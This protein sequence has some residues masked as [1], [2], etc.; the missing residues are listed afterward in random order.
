M[1]LFHLHIH[2]ELP[3]TFTNTRLIEVGGEH[4]LIHY[5][6]PVLRARLTKKAAKFYKQRLIRSKAEVSER[7]IRITLLLANENS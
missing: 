7:N 5:P 1:C 3:L 2:I 4:P 6:S